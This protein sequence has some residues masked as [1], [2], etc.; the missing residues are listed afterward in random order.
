MLQ[1]FYGFLNGRHQ[2]VFCKQ[3]RQQKTWI[4]IISDF[5]RISSNKTSFQIL[6]ILFG[7]FKNYFLFA[8]IFQINGALF[9]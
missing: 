8:K 6:I 1:F 4:Q 7:Y 2:I 9:V 5:Q 3:I